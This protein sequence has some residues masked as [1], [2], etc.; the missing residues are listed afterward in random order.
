MRINPRGNSS[1]EG[2]IA[3]KS[4]KPYRAGKRSRDWVKIKNS[5]TQSVVI[6]GWR[7][8]QGSRAATFGSLLVGIPEADG[9]RYVGRVGTGFDDTALEDISRR[10]RRIERKTSPFIEVPREVS[11]DAQ[12]VTPKLIGEV[13]FSEWT[14]TDRLRH[15]AWLGLRTDVDIDSIRRE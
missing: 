7:P 11:Q 2:I 6:G 9:L 3:K 5:R 4:D 10:L 15:P 1:H 8:G 13:E 14:S 12:W